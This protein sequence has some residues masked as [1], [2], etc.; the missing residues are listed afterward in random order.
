VPGPANPQTLNRFSYVRNNPLRYIDPSGHD[1]WWCTGGN[2]VADYYSDGS[3][4]DKRDLTTWFIAALVDSAE[5]PE[6]QR[7]NALNQPPQYGGNKRKAYDE[8]IYNVED[9]AKCDVKDK[10]EVRVGN[11]TKIGNNWYEYSTAGNILYGFYGKAA[12]FTDFELHAGAGKAQIDDYRR[13]P[14]N[15]MGGQKHSLTQKMTTLQ[16]DLG[17]IFIRIITM[18]KN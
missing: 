17:Y 10:I 9:G 14:K 8:F 5:S 18:T 13:D 11:P 4:A 3:T 6:M 2:C 1:P 12:G 15:R 7:I 16:L